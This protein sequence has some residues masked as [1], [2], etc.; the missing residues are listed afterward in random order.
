MKSVAFHF[1][2]RIHHAFGLLW[3]VTISPRTLKNHPIWSHWTEAKRIEEKCLKI[4]RRNY[5]KNVF[6]LFSTHN[7]PSSFGDIFM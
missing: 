6:F 1:S 7:C 2:P 5:F 4:C 3:I